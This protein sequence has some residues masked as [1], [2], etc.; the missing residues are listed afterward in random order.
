VRA[1][2][3][4]RLDAAVHACV[5][6]ERVV[7]DP[8]LGFAKQAEHD[9]ALLSGMSALHGL[10]RPLLIGPS[11]KRFLGRLLADP[12]GAPRPPAAR[13]A[14]TVALAGLVAANGAW[15]VRVHAAADAM[16]AVR[17]AAALETPN[18][19]TRSGDRS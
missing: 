12:A 18:Y 5:N 1:E 15:A 13:D 3:S 8:G 10:G 19:A 2:L 11:R 9:W 6:P 17:V 16:D 4:G 14:A 7:L